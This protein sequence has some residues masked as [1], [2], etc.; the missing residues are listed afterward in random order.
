MTG[1][2]VWEGLTVRALEKWQD[3]ALKKETKCFEEEQCVRQGWFG[4]TV[5][6]ESSILIQ[7]LGNCILERGC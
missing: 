6:E 7:G 4:G 2:S 5:R 3:V 1:R